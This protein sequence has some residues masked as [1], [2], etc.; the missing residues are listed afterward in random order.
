ML[1]NRIL[2]YPRLLVLAFFLF[3]CAGQV[4]PLGGPPDTVPPAVL[5]TV[6]DSNAVRVETDRVELEFSE[7]VDRLSV[8]D[9]ERAA[10]YREFL[11]APGSP[12]KVLR[13]GALIC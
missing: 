8:E 6:P 12:V 1:L 7:Y 5:R 3:S 10:R 2:L 4:P 13:A 9:I 11:S